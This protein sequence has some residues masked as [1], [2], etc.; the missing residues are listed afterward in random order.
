MKPQHA[1]DLFVETMDPIP[2]EHADQARKLL[3]NLRDIAAVHQSSQHTPSLQETASKL[4]S[5]ENALDCVA[6]Q[7]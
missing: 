3:E 1:A 5:K 6:T 7:A 2:K 4:S